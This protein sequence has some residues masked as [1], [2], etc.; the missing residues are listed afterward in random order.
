MIEPC[1]AFERELR[2]SVLSS[3]GVVLL[4]VPPVLHRVELVANSRISEYILH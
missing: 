2:V 4:G 3:I 1:A